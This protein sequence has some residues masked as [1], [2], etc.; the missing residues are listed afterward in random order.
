MEESLQ[1]LFVKETKGIVKM[2]N[3]KRKIISIIRGVWIRILTVIIPFTFP[4]QV[5]TF[6]HRLRGVKVGKSSK[7]ARTVQID[8]AYPH[9]V[10]IG[11]KVWITAGVLILC[12]QRDLSYYE[13]GKAV[14]DCPL[15]TGKVIIKD[16]SHIGIGAIIMPGVTIGEGSVIGAG[17]VVTKDIPPY[18]IAVGAPAKVIK[19]F[20]PKQ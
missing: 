11:N 10:E 1:N 12:H 18:S 8:D 16:G 4:T 15:R 5:T 2:A 17:S 20:N 9:L 3:N 7:I 6:L 19:S 14:M 13:I